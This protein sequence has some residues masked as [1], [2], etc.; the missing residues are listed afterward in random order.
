M[1]Y[2]DKNIFFNGKCEK[3]KKKRDEAWKKIK[4]IQSQRMKEKQTRKE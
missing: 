2:R 1:R 4:T 3:A